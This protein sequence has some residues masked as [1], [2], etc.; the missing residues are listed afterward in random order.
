MD[1]NKE[2]LKLLLEEERNSFNLKEYLAKLV[3]YWYWFVA[4]V[5]IVVGAAYVYNKYTPAVY[6][7]TSKLLVKDPDNQ[8]L[9]LG[10]IFD[11]LPLKKQVVLENHIGIMQSYNLNYEVVNRLGW[12]VS[13][14]KE[15]PLGDLDCYGESPYY[16]TFNPEDQNIK[17]VPIHIAPAG[18][19]NYLVEVD[20]KVKVNGEEFQVRF[21]SKGTYGQKFE[22]NYFNFTIN[23][24][25]I[26]GGGEYYFVFN[27][28]EKVALRYLSKLKIDIENKDANILNVSVKGNNYK[29]EIDYINTL[30]SVYE[31]Y[32][33]RS[34][35]QISENTIAFIDRQL[36]AVVDTLRTTS[37][38][39]TN[40][41]SNKKVYDLGQK[42]EIIMQK[43]NE[44]DSRKA[45]AEMQLRYYEDLKKYMSDADQMKNVTFP[46]VAGITDPGLNNLVVKLSELYSKKEA[47]SYSL[48]AKNPSLVLVER[49]L[50]YTRKSL[51]EN[52]NNLVFNAQRD[53]DAINNEIYLVNSQ[54]SDVPRTEQDMVNMKRMVDLN[55]ELYN[56]LLQR[57]AE[58]EIAKASCLPEIEV[59]DPAQAA[60]VVD[61]GFTTAVMMGIALVLGLII[62]F[63]VIMMV[64]YLDNTVRTKEQLE[65][66]TGIPLVAEIVRNHS[67]DSI[68]VVKYM[69]SVIAESFRKLRTSLTYLSKRDEKTVIAVHSSVPGEGKTFVTVNLAAALALNN[70]KV[71]LVGAD[72]RKPLVHNYFN[73]KNETGMSTYLVGHHRLDDI[74]KHTD[75]ENLDVILCGAV[76]PNPADL[77]ASP[78]FETLIE[79]LR[80]R[81]EIILFD[82]SPF[83]LVADA[84]IVGKHADINLFVVRQGYT[85]HNM[86]EILNYQVEQFDLKKAGI[87]LNDIKPGKYGTYTS[88]YAGYTSN[89]LKAGKGYFDDAVSTGKKASNLTEQAVAG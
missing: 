83:T 75:I 72:L 57:R 64:S 61:S 5:I 25:T 40:F 53:L 33:V 17:Q 31:T 69:R 58:A 21:S 41:R 42:A 51:Q 1:D 52:L 70:K 78:E 80:K 65:R 84:A 81:Y 19:Q 62:P 7:V 87:I 46:S 37:T 26:D 59:L 32:S 76:P 11:A 89:S 48:Q 22:N 35:S 73:M 24:T 50:D 12:N 4:S 6:Q 28:L 79:D 86:V 16:V 44:L 8:N 85:T 38:Q 66:L 54:L 2:I 43:A 14:Y 71:V 45:I 23:K 77:L 30:A 63:V 3:G 15:M 34:R 60:T 36:N 82:N 74:I 67:K 27:N 29:R 10:G 56:F 18:S 20:S 49:E 47:L 39:F 55:N 13:W 88:A 9:A 68:P